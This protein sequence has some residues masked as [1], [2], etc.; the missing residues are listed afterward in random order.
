LDFYR[1]IVAYSGSG[2][3]GLCHI[4]PGLS[5]GQKQCDWLVL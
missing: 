4:Q 5:A 3:G 1:I 2:V